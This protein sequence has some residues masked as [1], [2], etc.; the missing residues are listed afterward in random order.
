MIAR[1]LVWRTGAVLAAASTLA[2]VALPA[3]LP[4]SA[5]E[6]PTLVVRLSSVQPGLPP[7]VRV[8]VVDSE[9]TYLALGNQGSTA[10]YAVDPDGRPFLQ[11]SS[12]GVFGDAD[13]RYLGASNDVLKSAGA[14]PRGCCPAGRWVRLSTKSAWAWPDPRLDPPLR[15]AANGDDRGLGA[16]SS[17]EPLARWQI[18]LRVDNRTFA[19]DGVI[20]RRQVGAVTTTIDAAPR[21]LKTTVIE[22]R[23]PQ[24]RIEVREDAKLSVLGR[25]GR[26]FLRMGPSGTFARSDS[27]EYQRSRRAMGLRPKAGRSWVPMPGARPT[28][29]VWADTRLD[30][31]AKLPANGTDKARLI[32]EWRIPVIVDGRRDEI[33]G[34]SIWESVTPPEIGNTGQSSFQ[35]AGDVTTYLVAGGLTLTLLATVVFARRRGGGTVGSG[36]RNQ[37]LER[38]R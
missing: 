32:N 35:D 15:D 10:A 6:D 24:L 38:S 9:Q 22:S 2:V 30:Y 5:H 1:L 14:A 3:P 4:A 17:D 27:D 21:G 28:T 26:T 23:P 8:D 36:E 7:D 33:R 20:E 25:D 16:M 29:V 31:Q 18:P 37:L 19:V 34:K 12:A 13:S 11:V